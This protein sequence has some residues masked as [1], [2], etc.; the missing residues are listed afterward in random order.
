MNSSHTYVGLSRRRHGEFFCH[1]VPVE[2]CPSATLKS[3][4]FWC[5]RVTFHAEGLRGLGKRD[6]PVPLRPCLQPLQ[7]QFADSDS[8]QQGAALSRQD[9]FCCLHFYI[10][11]WDRLL[12][13]DLLLWNIRNSSSTNHGEKAC[14]CIPVCM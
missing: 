13:V 4:Q 5:K 1:A 12:R 10:V 11:F 14:K 6:A 7:T 9:L 8:L 3:D 2:L